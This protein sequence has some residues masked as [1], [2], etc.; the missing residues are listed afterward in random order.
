VHAIREGTVHEAAEALRLALRSLLRRGSATPSDWLFHGAD[1]IPRL[2]RLEIPGAANEQ[3]LAQALSLRLVEAVESLP[4]PQNEAARFLFG[5]A[6]QSRGL[7]L[8]D[9]RARAAEC[10]D[11]QPD[12]LRAHVEP[13]L[14]DGLAQQLAL[15]LTLDRMVLGTSPDEARPAVDRRT[16]LIVHGRDSAAA[17]DVQRFVESLGLRAMDWKEALDQAGVSSPSIVDSLRATLDVAQAVV[18]LLEP[19]EA[20]AN[21]IFE[22][23]VFLGIA[24]TRTVLVQVG[25]HDLPSDLHGVHIVQ[26]R[27]ATATRSALRSAL[28]RAGCDVDERAD[29]WQDPQRAGDLVSGWHRW[30]PELA[31]NP[32]F[33]DVAQAVENFQPEDTAAGNAAAAWLKA[34]ALHDHDSVATHLL[35]RSG[36]LEGFVAVAAGSIALHSRKRIRDMGREP[37]PTVHPATLVRWMEKHREANPAVSEELLLYTMG[38]ALDVSG[39]L[40]SIALVLQPYDDVQAKRWSEDHPLLRLDD[41]G[42]VLWFPLSGSATSR[43]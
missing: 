23:G 12:S 8:R 38:L 18:V 13:R 14:L 1:V 2:R 27:N 28:E 34:H 31:E 19:G 10:F 3:A 24:P 20:R 42:R 17:A 30:T 9:R 6:P 16:V 36:R 43:V 39:R 32:A 21:V 40:G 7:K 33:A 11:V 25:T 35:V 41:S 4:G 29:D 37:V 5:L 15:L 26:L 22:A